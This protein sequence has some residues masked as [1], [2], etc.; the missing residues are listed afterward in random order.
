MIRGDTERSAV[1][2]LDETINY[3]LLSVDTVKLIQKNGKY[4][5]IESEEEVP[6][7]T[8]LVGEVKAGDKVAVHWGW[9]A[10]KM[11]SREV[12]N[13]KYWTERFI[14]SIAFN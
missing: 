4:K 8:P 7:L 6:Y 1:E 11:E 9:V 10:G 12:E 3:Q 2:G 14:N 5:L 13:I